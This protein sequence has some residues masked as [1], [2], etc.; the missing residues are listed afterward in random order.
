M[1]AP[2]AVGVDNNDLALRTAANNGRINGL[3]ERMLLIKAHAE[4]MLPI[5]ADLLIANIHYS[6]LSLL[7]DR[8]EFYGRR[9]YVV[10]G[11]IRGEAKAIEERLKG[12]L[13]LVDTYCEEFWSTYLFS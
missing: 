9:Y 7:V 5:E 12:K 11:M 13:E 8:P 3:A 2:L 10:S 1:G 6:A 4:E